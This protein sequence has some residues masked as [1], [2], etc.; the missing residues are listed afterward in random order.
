M[1]L[2]V[3]RSRIKTRINEKKQ[4]SKLRSRF[5]SHSAFMYPGP[6]SNR[7]SRKNRIL[8]PAR[9]PVPPPRHSFRLSG[10][11]RYKQNSNQTIQIQLDVKLILATFKGSQKGANSVFIKNLPHETHLI[12][13]G[14]IQARTPTSLSSKKTPPRRSKWV[15]RKGE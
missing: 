13:M 5:V 15:P 6:E 7:H 2:T 8:N 10:P 14:Q 11:Q 4:S 9:L 12:Q 3:L 1:F